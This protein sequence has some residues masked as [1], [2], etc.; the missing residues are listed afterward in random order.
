MFSKV[1]VE[2]SGKVPTDLKKTCKEF[3]GS[4]PNFRQCEGDSSWQFQ[5]VD[6]LE[7]IEHL[8]WALYS[9]QVFDL[10]GHKIKCDQMRK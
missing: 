8:E 1:G 7:E 6:V 4:F 5:M 10:K 3:R 2:T 9:G